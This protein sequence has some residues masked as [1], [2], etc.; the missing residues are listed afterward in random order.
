MRLIFTAFLFLIS[1]IALGQDTIRI[2]HYNLLNYGNNYGDCNNSNNNVNDKNEYLKVIV[3]F[4]K[5]DVLSVNEIDESNSYHENILNNVLNINGISDFKRGDPPNLSYSP[6]MNEIYYN[7]QKLTLISNFVVETNYRDIDIFNFIHKNNQWGDTIFL[8]NIVAHLKAGNDPE[9]AQERASETYK[10]MNFL[11]NNNLDGNY[12]ISGDLNLQKS[13][14]SAFQNLIAHTNEEIRF[15]DP[16]NKIGDWHN[17]PSYASVHTQSTH[18]N[19]GCAAGGGMDDRFDFFLASDEIMEGKEHIKYVLDSYRAVGQDGQRFNESLI[20]PANNS[21]PAEVVS[22]LYAMSDHL[23]I[24]MDLAI[25]AQIGN[26][27]TSKSGLKLSFNNPAKG[28]I[29][30]KVSL[31]GNNMVEVTLFDFLGNIHHYSLRTIS[32]TENITIPVSGLAEG[33]YLLK[34]TSQGEMPVTAKVMLLK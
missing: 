28:T 23:P 13:G 32:T 3:D 4:L 22:A 15:Y 17:N 33:V 27:T 5:P 9:D 8:H 1:C 16:I 10:L 7:S 11:H 30:L 14:E 24:V 26:V 18:V 2:M 19:N 12:L 29:H 34:I 31:P 25:G 21:V 6:I 20:N